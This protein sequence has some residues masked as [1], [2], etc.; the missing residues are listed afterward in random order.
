MVELTIEEKEELRALLENK[1][2]LRAFLENGDGRIP[3]LADLPAWWDLASDAPDPE[4]D[5]CSQRAFL[6]V[7]YSSWAFTETWAWEGLRRLLDTLLE[8]HEPVPE[9]LRWVWV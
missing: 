2:E 5:G 3:E 4:L 9:F 7:C 8:R 1:E 6:I